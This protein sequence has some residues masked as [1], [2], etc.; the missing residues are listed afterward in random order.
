M[1]QS[2]IFCAAPLGFEGLAK[3]RRGRRSKPPFTN[4]SISNPPGRIPKLVLA[5]MI[6]ALA[7]EA[8]PSPATADAVSGRVLVTDGD[9]IVIGD[10]RIRLEGIDAPETDQ[11][12]LDREQR[13]FPCGMKAREVLQELIGNRAIT[14]IGDEIDR[15]GRR[16]MTCSAAG[17]NLNAAMV[18]AGWALAYVRYSHRYSAQEID[19]REHA[20]GMWAGAFIAPWDWRHRDRNTVILGSISVPVTA[21][22]ALLPANP[23]SLPGVQGCKIK[24]NIS[25]NGA[26]IYHLP[27]MRD[28]ERTKINERVGERWFCTE[29]EARA[30]GWRRARR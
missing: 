12:C 22:G 13:R 17:R 26:R 20:S 27:G 24:G 1:A 18:Q 25:K 16:L 10:V 15:Y 2:S 28:Y 11:I 8:S 21:Q 14:C 23:V 9:T 30:A 3:R 5:A 19:A 4:S 29:H 7:I 6:A